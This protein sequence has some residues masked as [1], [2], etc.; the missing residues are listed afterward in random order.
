[1]SWILSQPAREDLDSILGYVE[2][3]SGPQAA[4]RL[5]D[6]FIAAFDLLATSPRMGRRAQLPR[7]ARW[8]LVHSYLILYHA[9]VEP[10][11]IDRIL[12]GARDLERILRLG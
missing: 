12:H 1:M 9:E 8:W 10:I 3:E 4:D 6:D 11:E 2:R 7:E 5:L